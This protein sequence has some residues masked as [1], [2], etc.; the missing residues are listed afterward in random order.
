[1]KTCCKCKIEKSESEFCRNKSTA[2]GLQKY[3]KGCKQTIART[4]YMGSGRSLHLESVRK[5][6]ARYKKLM[7]DFVWNYLKQHP[8]QLCGETDPI[9]L[10]FDHLGDVKK[11]NEIS[12]LMC[13]STNIN[14]LKK[15]I[16]KCQVLC[17]YCHKRKTAKEFNHWKYV[18]SI[19]E[20]SHNSNG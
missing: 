19:S 12:T 4:W 2:D 13:N 16:Q 18:K 1:M 8:C 6:N 14:V 10:E 11:E 15:E 3:C 5:N 7:Q 20:C 9:V 17:S